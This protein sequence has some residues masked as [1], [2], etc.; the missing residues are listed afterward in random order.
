MQ[1]S[2]LFYSSALC[3]RQQWDYYQITGNL[4]RRYWVVQGTRGGHRIEY[5]QVESRISAIHGGPAQ[6]PY[7]GDLPYQVPNKITFESLTNIQ[8]LLLD[9]KVIK[10]VEN[11]VLAAKSDDRDVLEQ[12][13][14]DVWNHMSNQIEESTEELAF[15]LKGDMH[16]APSGDST[17]IHQE[18]EAI[19]ESFIMGGV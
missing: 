1:D 14:K 6:P 19:E 15:H 7:A 4:L 11:G 3:S 8:A 17:A 12:M 5:S 16:M 9:L 18:L 13:R 10:T 2:P